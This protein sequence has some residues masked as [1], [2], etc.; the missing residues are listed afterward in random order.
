MSSFI[1]YSLIGDKPIYEN[2]IK[3]KK[4]L[5]ATE[6]IAKKERIYKELHE[7]ARGP[8]DASDSIGIDGG[9]EWPWADSPEGLY[10]RGT[11]Q[12][13][14]PDTRPLYGP[15]KKI[16]IN[17]SD[18]GPPPVPTQKR[19]KKPE[20]PKRMGRPWKPTL[21]FRNRSSQEIL[22]EIAATGQVSYHPDIR[23][24][25]DHPSLPHRI[26]RDLLAN[27][28]L[29]DVLHN[30]HKLGKA[31]S[32]GISKQKGF[33]KR[34]YR[35]ADV[36]KELSADLGI[37]APRFKFEYHPNFIGTAT[38]NEI[39]LNPAMFKDYGPEAV[40][41]HELR[42]VKERRLGH[43]PLIDKS[44]AT[45]LFSGPSD[46]VYQNLHNQFALEENLKK[47]HGKTLNFYN[48]KPDRLFENDKIKPRLDALDIFDFMEKGHFK[49]SFMKENL[50]RVAK[51]LPII[52]AALTTM[53][54][55]G[56]SDASAG[57]ADAVIP[58]GVESLG[59]SDKE[60][61][62]MIKEAY[63]KRMDEKRKRLNSLIE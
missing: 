54:V 46:N 53:G 30:Q 24:V 6:D 45:G 41:A 23:G 62:R 36:I 33:D 12:K 38:D 7:M 2:I 59:H 51:G 31:L 1:N 5:R 4:E 34:R 55:L 32:E 43:K 29:G 11:P 52:G 15:A 48:K 28:V 27:E 40:I 37:D 60:Q 57:V 25:V 16:V 35:T 47:A 13:V 17:P 58:G 14:L 3:K 61:Q 42:H 22:D 39:M 63:H 8:L 20:V 18:S 21:D 26:E 56:S 9:I 19:P 49:D 10:R 44:L 50:K